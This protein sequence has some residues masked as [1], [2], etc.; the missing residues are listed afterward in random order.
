M[1]ATSRQEWASVAV[2]GA[3]AVGYLTAVNAYNAE[4]GPLT[5]RWFSVWAG[6][7]LLSVFAW[8]GVLAVGVQRVRKTP[9]AAHWSAQTKYVAL[10]ALTVPIMFT[11]TRYAA[12]TQGPRSATMTVIFIGLYVFGW[13][14]GAPWAL[15]VW[16]A[17]RNPALASAVAAVRPS[18][19]KEPATQAELDVPAILTGVAELRRT[20]QTIE[21]SAIAFAVILSTAVLNT[22]MLR[23]AA[24][25]SG[26]TTA[27]DAPVVFVLAYGAFFAAVVF[28][29]VAPLLASWRA[30]ATELAARAL[31]EPATGVPTA[32]YVSAHDRFLNHLGLRTGVLRTPIAAISILA[33]LATAFVTALVPTD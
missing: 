16:H 30:Q 20:W 26:T 4:G 32:E 13:I 31:G 24:I 7:V 2:L 33:P 8:V 10:A 27:Q 1:A 25:G 18:A 29:V 14:A 21:E 9:G 15:Q 17:H 22:A 6:L 19:P 3:G 23:L 28:A 11:A 5:T 12:L